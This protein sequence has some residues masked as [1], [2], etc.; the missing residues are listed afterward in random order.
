[1][2]C[3]VCT[4]GYPR[5]MRV[6]LCLGAGGI[7]G[8]SYLC[9]ALEGVRR[10][11]GFTPSDAR[12]VLGTSAGAF[13][14]ALSLTTSVPLLYT[15]CTGIEA[16]GAPLSSHEH[17]RASR[18]DRHNHG[19]FLRRYPPVGRMPRPFLSSSATV[20]RSIVDREARSAEL[21]ALRARIHLARGAIDRSIEDL[22]AALYLEPADLVSRFHYA[23]ALATARA[24]TS[25]V[26]SGCPW[27]VWVQVSRP[28]ILYTY[29]IAGGAEMVVVTNPSTIG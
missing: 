28:L 13:M 1:M 9:G 11:T 5:T 15:H 21:L 7:V 24:C 14:G 16:P 20:R 12:I 22:R 3:R 25:R 29:L 4:C 10:S 17:E 27:H 6:G 26:H 18:L 8:A 2:W 23:H 19:S